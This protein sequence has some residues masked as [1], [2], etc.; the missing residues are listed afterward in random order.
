MI[1]NWYWYY[2]YNQK[3][4]TNQDGYVVRCGGN[5]GRAQKNVVNIIMIVK[6]NQEALLV[7]LH[8]SQFH[9]NLLQVLAGSAT[10]W[11]PL[12]SGIL[13]PGGD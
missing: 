13:H 3:K 10:S 8:N 5:R 11:K 9:K 7:L 6:M 1:F 2:Y 12:I 4:W